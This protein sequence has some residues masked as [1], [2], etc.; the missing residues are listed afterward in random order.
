LRPGVWSYV[1]G[2]VGL[3][4][5]LGTA[6]WYVAAAMYVPAWWTVILWVAYAGLLAF[7]VYLMRMSPGWVLAMPVLSLIAL[8]LLTG[9]FEF[10]VFFTR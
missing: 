4:A 9:V 1:F 2:S 10:L 8:A 3:L 6:Y 7:A 5:F